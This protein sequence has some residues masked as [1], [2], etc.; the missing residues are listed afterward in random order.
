[1]SEEEILA[2]LENRLRLYIESTSD[3]YH[4]DEK[5]YCIKL[6]LD[7]DCISSIYFDAKS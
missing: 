2:I 6:M 7:A 4:P 3:F 1:M 5:T